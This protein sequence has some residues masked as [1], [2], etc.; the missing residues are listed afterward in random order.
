MK[1]LLISCGFRSG[2]G[3]LTS[4][5]N[6]NKDVSLCADMVKYWNFCYGRYPQLDSG[7]VRVMLEELRVRLSIRF[8]INLDV[9]K[10]VEKVG[11]E[12]SHPR[13]YESLMLE[14]FSMDAGIKIAGECEGL[15][16]SKMSYFLDNV[17]DSKGIIIIRDPRDVLVSF[18]K[19][20]IA[21]GDAY[22]VSIFNSLGLMSRALEYTR[23]YE[24]RFMSV[25]F[26]DLKSNPEAVIKQISQFLGIMYN[27]DMMDPKNWTKLGN[28]TWI[29]WEN[30]DSS[31]FRED[32]T[33]KM[34]P[35][36]RWKS[37]I[38]PEDHFV[39]EWV[40]GKIMKEFGYVPN[41]SGPS[42]EMFDSALRRLLSSELLKN[43]LMDYLIHANGAEKYPLDPFNPANWDK[44]YIDNPEK[45][46]QLSN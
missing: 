21:T 39:C 8:S 24:G 5:L 36:G 29:P 7:S 4:M 10:V 35:V 23:R 42:V 17:Q 37:M 14:I 25:R 2:A 1:Y 41:F 27:H 40:N 13:V 11:E 46:S 22:L 34:Q 26:E 28:K 45:L 32:Q 43:C 18:K 3:L 30:H 33:K 44:R 16:W 9:E 15:T 38:T 19:N 31:S 6:A 12:L 20:T